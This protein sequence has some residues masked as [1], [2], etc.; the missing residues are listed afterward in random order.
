MSAKPIAPALIV[1]IDLTAA[2]RRLSRGSVADGRVN[3]GR[4]NICHKRGRY[5]SIHGK[6]ADPALGMHSDFD[7]SVE[8]LARYVP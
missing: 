5:I 3:E 8:K 6:A 1:L 7:I 2:L 4:S